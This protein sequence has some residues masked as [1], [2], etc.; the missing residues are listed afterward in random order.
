MIVLS[1]SSRRTT[2]GRDT[3]A[4]P[5]CGADDHYGAEHVDALLHRHNIA[6]QK[7]PQ[8]APHRVRTVVFAS[9]DCSES[10]AIRNRLCYV[11]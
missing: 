5:P 6:G 1:S 9:I 11:A 8:L 7:M 4:A 3:R 10:R 2:G